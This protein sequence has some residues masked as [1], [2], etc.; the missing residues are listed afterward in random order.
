MSDKTIRIGIIG[1]GF[2]RT[3]QIPGFKA[4]E[5]AKFIPALD[6]GKPVAGQFNL[7]VDFKMV[8]NPDEQAFGSHLK[9]RQE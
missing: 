9:Q 3:T 8:T 2:A 4:C 7:A 5:G 6:N 1:A